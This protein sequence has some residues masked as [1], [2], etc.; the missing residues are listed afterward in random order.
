MRPERVPR[1]GEPVDLPHV[2]PHIVIESETHKGIGRYELTITEAARLRDTLARVCDLAE[3]AID[4]Y[5]P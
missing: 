1:E 2:E 4:A 3:D 5:A